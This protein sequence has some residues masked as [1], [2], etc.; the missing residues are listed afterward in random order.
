MSEHVMKIGGRE[1]RAEVV[2]LRA[3]RAVVVVDGTEYGV[4]L[5]H[6]GQKRVAPTEVSRPVPAAPPVPMN[7]GAPMPPRAA[8]PS[9]GEGGITTPMPGLIFQVRV[10]EGETVQA[11]QTLLI[12]EAMKMENAITSP[13]HGVVSKLYVREGDDVSEG[14]LLVDVARPQLTAL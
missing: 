2:E 7:L 6:L 13:Y 9:T 11:G 12:L 3:D 8:S 1:Y 4:D 5:V 14:D 10:K